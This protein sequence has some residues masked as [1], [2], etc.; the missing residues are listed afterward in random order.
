MKGI[1]L[2][3][4][5]L[6]HSP[7]TRFAPTG[8]VWEHLNG[9]RSD[10]EWRQQLQQ[11]LGPENWNQKP[12]Q[13][14]RHCTAFVL[15]SIQHPMAS[16]PLAHPQVLFALTA[17]RI[18]L[19]HSLTFTCGYFLFAQQAVQDVFAQIK[20]DEFV[21]QTAG[22]VVAVRLVLQSSVQLSKSLKIWRHIDSA[23]EPADFCLPPGF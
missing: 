15:P 20:D 22:L 10:K 18:Q 23:V 16:V 14:P 5:L 19:S 3:N 12:V 13:V 4:L 1:F 11:Q 6:L 9:E 2:C 17:I 21:T 7:P 8:L